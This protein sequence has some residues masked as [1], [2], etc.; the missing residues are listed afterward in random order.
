MDVGRPGNKDSKFFCTIQ[1]F[2]TVQYA[3]VQSPVAIHTA[4]YLPGVGE[5][6][7]PTSGINSISSFTAIVLQQL[8]RL[9][10]DTDF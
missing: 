1:K 6:P 7:S 8:T 5:Y 4:F 2:P 10:Q 9:A 3:A